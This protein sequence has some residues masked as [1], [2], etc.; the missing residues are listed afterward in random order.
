MDI[1]NNI[2]FYKNKSVIASM[3]YAILVMH[4]K[5]CDICKICDVCNKYLLKSCGNG[6]K[7]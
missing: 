4:I 1:V 5:I 6:M 7:R 2:N 3:F